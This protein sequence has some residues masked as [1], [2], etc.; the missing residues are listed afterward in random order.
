MG[1]VLGRAKMI[2]TSPF[3]PGRDC[4]FFPVTDP[5]FL[6][7]YF[8]VGP[9]AGMNDPVVEDVSGHRQKMLEPSNHAK[10][11]LFN[12]KAYNRQTTTVGLRKR[13]AIKKRAG[14]N[15]DFQFSFAKN[16]Y[17]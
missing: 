15:H 13:L 10:L 12:S 17:D 14:N 1:V 4:N 7:R 16:F 6:I 11:I 8:P 9:V 3:I 2:K 5:F